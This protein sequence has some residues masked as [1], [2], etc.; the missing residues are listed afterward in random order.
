VSFC[1]RDIAE[2]IRTPTPVRNRAC[3]RVGPDKVI[4]TMPVP[5]QVQVFSMM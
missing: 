5:T 3:L 4:R 1:V 2:C